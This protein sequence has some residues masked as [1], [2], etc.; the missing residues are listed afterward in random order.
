MI[1]AFHK[2]MDNIIFMVLKWGHYGPGYLAR[3]THGVYLA[4]DSLDFEMELVRWYGIFERHSSD[5][6]GERHRIDFGAFD[7]LKSAQQACETHA[8][9]FEA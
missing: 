7:A 5:H 9:E 2:T 6:S 4:Y 3:S 8:Q 1:L